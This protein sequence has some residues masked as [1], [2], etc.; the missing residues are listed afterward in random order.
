[1]ELQRPPE[2]EPGLEMEIGVIQRLQNSKHIVRFI[3]EGKV[4]P[5]RYFIMQLLGK[6]L[7]DLRMCNPKYRFTPNTSTR[8]AMQCFEAIQ[9]VH[10]IGILHRDIKPANFAIG[11]TTADIRNIFVLEF[12]MVRRFL[13]KDGS[14]RPA[15][16]IAGFR[17][18]FL[19]TVAQQYFA[20]LIFNTYFRNSEVR[21][22]KRA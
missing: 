20:E 21:F 15:R 6:N 13:S 19:P 18:K 7:G 22:N 2:D 10:R 3:D 12:G 9:D 8:V 11:R 1:M 4:G 5:F 16:P 14:L 17:G